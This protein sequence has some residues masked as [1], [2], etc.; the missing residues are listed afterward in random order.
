MSES[1]NPIRAWQ[2]P[3][4]TTLSSAIPRHRARPVPSRHRQRQD[5]VTPQDT[6]S[7]AVAKELSV[8]YVIR[9]YDRNP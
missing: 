5:T 6:V 2:S 9:A 4:Q 3:G 7:V 8:A 1:S